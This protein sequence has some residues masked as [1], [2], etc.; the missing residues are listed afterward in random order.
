VDSPLIEREIIRLM[1]EDYWRVL[2]LS[3]FTTEQAMDAYDNEFRQRLKRYGEK[4]PESVQMEI[5]EIV[6]TETKIFSDECERDARGLR[7]R[8]CG[9][10]KVEEVHRVSYQRQGIG[11]LAVRTAVRATVWEL[12]FS[13]FRR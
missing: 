13:I 11:E 4:F 3:N 10:Q 1:V 12:I 5:I 6:K 8:L 9:P 2:F 7:A